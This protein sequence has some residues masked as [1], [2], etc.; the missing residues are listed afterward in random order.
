MAIRWFDDA[1]DQT[2]CVYEYQGGQQHFP[3][4]LRRSTSVSW[5]QMNR[6]RA[7]WYVPTRQEMDEC[8]LV[9]VLPGDAATRCILFVPM[10]SGDQ[11]R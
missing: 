10:L 5:Q 11:L 4:P 7:A 6:R 3:P 1:A 9:N 2:L 8:G